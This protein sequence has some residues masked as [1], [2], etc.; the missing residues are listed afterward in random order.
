VV[1]DESEKCLHERVQNKRGAC[2][3]MAWQQPCPRG[4]RRQ[5]S[6]CVRVLVPDALEETDSCLPRDMQARIARTFSLTPPALRASDARPPKTPTAP[7]DFTF[8]VME[9]EG[10]N[11][12]QWSADQRE[13]LAGTLNSAFAKVVVR[14][15]VIM[16]RT[17]RTKATNEIK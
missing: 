14:P 5:H 2:L 11:R 6:S 15:A 13:C 8:E 17:D 1:V 3:L 10:P 7:K 16:K 9:K 4:V 12:L